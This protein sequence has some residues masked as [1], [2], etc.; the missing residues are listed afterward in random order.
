[1]K[2]VKYAP[3][4]LAQP[5]MDALSSEFSKLNPQTQEEIESQ[6]QAGKMHLLVAHVGNKLKGGMVVQGRKTPQGPT[7]F[8]YGIFGKDIAKQE[9]F[10]EAKKLLKIAGFFYIEGFGSSAILRTYQKA[11]LPFSA[12]KTTSN[13]VFFGAKL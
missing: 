9:Y 5:F 13:G 10:K 6:I 7:A 3:K 11:G 8:I 12:T 4:E 2:T 1:M